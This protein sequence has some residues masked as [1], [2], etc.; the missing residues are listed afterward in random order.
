MSSD[1]H[2]K[3]N[4]PFFQVVYLSINLIF[5]LF[6]RIV[7]IY[8]IYDDAFSIKV[9]YIRNIFSIIIY[10]PVYHLFGIRGDFLSNAIIVHKIYINLL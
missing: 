6:K 5:K 9:S 2:N 10:I 3:T 4:N 1:K 8:I 7:T